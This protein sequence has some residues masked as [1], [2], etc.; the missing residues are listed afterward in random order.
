MEM[1]K[2]HTKISNWDINWDINRDINDNK[3][4]NGWNH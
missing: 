3:M 2:S 4:I 1:V